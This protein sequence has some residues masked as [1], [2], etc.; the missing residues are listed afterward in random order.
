ME[1]I[2]NEKTVDLNSLSISELEQ[3]V[4]DVK[5]Y[6]NSILD[7]NSCLIALTFRDNC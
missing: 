3:M 5:N 1:N 6:Y 2:E 7:K 4:K